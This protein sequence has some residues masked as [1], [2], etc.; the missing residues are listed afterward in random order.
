MDLMKVEEKHSQE[1]SAL[2][3][4]LKD[5]A[6]QQDSLSARVEAAPEVAALSTRLADVE[7][8][9]LAAAAKLDTLSELPSLSKRLADVEVLQGVPQI[10]PEVLLEMSTFSQR[11]AKLE[12][13]DH[14]IPAPGDVAYMQKLKDL[15]E[16][17]HLAVT[18][19]EAALDAARTGI[20]RLTRELHWEREDRKKVLSDVKSLSQDL[21]ILDTVA[22]QLRSEMKTAIAHES[23][24]QQRASDSRMQLVIAELR[25][26]T[27][28]FG[29]LENIPMKSSATV[30]WEGPSKEWL[31]K[32]ADGDL[33]STRSMLMHL[34]V[35]ERM[36]V[37]GSTPDDLLSRPTFRC[38]HRVVVAMK[39][40]TGY[41]P[42]IL[43]DWPGPAEAK[44]DFVRK[45]WNWVAAT[46]GLQGTEFNAQDV[47]HCTNRKK[48]RRLLQLLAIAASKERGSL[49]AT[50]CIQT[51]TAPSVC[52]KVELPLLTVPAV[53]PSEV[54]PSDSNAVT[55]GCW[56]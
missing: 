43:E 50:P 49:R 15:E 5:L 17:H 31:P 14:T 52:N 19:L 29:A 21:G 44:V 30:P 37:G 42:G 46:L 51:S 47:L 25:G 55:T 24:K 9:Q 13:L 38:L 56:H 26:G 4:R 32:D 34:H 18:K 33:E 22:K 23:A 3:N 40:A 45:V 35:F 41:P 6:E 11:L 16:A 36:A 54:V 8:S 12:A 53:K 27:E 28:A 1:V 39:Q 7:A 20:A 48:T 10:A 2:S